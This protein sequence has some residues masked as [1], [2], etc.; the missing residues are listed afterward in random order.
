MVAPKY[1]YNPKTLRY[2]RAGLSI[3]SI[4]FTT[5]GILFTGALFF[6]GLFMLQA[7]LIT[8]ST[9]RKLQAENKALKEHHSIISSRIAA[10]K[11]KLAALREREDDLTRKF[12]DI[13]ESANDHHPTP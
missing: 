13:R 12:F 10:G 11:V 7:R 6:A 1:Y 3:R 5:I 2:E 9:E 8:T 4:L